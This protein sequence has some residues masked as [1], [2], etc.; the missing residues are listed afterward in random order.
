MDAS[1][2]VGQPTSPGTS[3]CACH[4]SPKPRIGGVAQVEE[5]VPVAGTGD[6]LAAAASAATVADG[7]ES[8]DVVA[9]GAG[10]SGVAVAPGVAATVGGDATVG[11]AGLA[12]A[13]AVGVAAVCAAVCVTVVGA[14]CAAAA[15]LG[16]DVLME[17]GPVELPVVAVTDGAPAPCALHAESTLTIARSP[18]IAAG[19]ERC[20]R[21]STVTKPASLPPL[22]LE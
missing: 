5:A 18:T 6:P 8:G 4:T 3:E 20:Q 7:C 14:V 10:V 1:A 16:T 22:F 19:I 12:V 15:T 11:V 2:P 13:T 17:A 9:V 21:W